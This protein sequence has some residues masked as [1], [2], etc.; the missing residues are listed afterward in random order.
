M[1]R[2]K[3]QIEPSEY[4]FSTDRLPPE[5]LAS[6]E[7]N[8]AIFGAPSPF[9]EILDDSP[10]FI[11][12]SRNTGILLLYNFNERKYTFMG[13]NA[14]ENKHIDEISNTLENLVKAHKKLKEINKHF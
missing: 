12:K 11:Y 14:K 10:I 13:T 7:W 5:Y 3:R 9:I 2:K 6:D 1:G 4:T 8:N